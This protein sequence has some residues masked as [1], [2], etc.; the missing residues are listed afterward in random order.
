VDITTTGTGNVRLQS[1][2]GAA[3]SKGLTLAGQLTGSGNLTVTRSGGEEGSVRLA[4]NSN[5][6]NGTITV[7]NAGGGAGILVLEA[8]GAATS[9][10]L[11]LASSGAHLNVNTAN[12]T[13]AE[14]SGVSG[15]QVSAR[16][17]GQ[18]LTVN[19]SADTTFAGVLGGTGVAGSNAGLAFIKDGGGTLTLSGTST[20]TGDTTV[21]AGTLLVT[22]A[23]GATTVTVESGAAIGGNGNLGGSLIFD[24]GAILDLTAASIGLNNIDI[25]DVSGAI[26]LNNFAFANLV[27]WDWANAAEGTYTLIDGGSTVTLAGTTPTASNP[28]DF[29]N[30]RQGYFQAGSLQVVVIPEPGVA[31]LGGLGFLVLLR[32]RR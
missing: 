20:H 22:G 1:Q 5:T 18:T 25:L 32:R 11:N 3:N 7:N 12:A 6:Y 21:S 10:R 14:L 13:I 9:A 24:P 31:L 29:G 30:G 26:T 17:A 2:W 4:N 19:Q 8:N 15:S 16:S 28:Y 27:G 23:L